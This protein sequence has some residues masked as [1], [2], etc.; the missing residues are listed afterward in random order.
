MDMVHKQKFDFK[1]WKLS[2]TPSV[3]LTN[4]AKKSHKPFELKE[5]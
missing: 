4:M 1:L 2:E 3:C 5:I